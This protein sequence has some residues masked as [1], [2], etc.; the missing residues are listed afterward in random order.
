MQGVRTEFVDALPA[1]QACEA[2][3]GAYGGNPRLRFELGRAHLA[4]QE[5]D[6]ARAKIVKLGLNATLIPT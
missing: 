3:V 5:A 6:K 2:A 1:I 4:N